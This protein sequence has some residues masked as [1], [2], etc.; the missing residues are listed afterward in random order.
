MNEPGPIFLGVNIDHVAT[1]RQARRTIEPDPVWAAALAEL[2][3]ADGIDGYGKG[4]KQGELSDAVSISFIIQKNLGCFGDG[5]AV[6]TNN[7]DIDRQV[8]ILRNH[9]SKKRSWHSPGFNSRLDDLQAGVLGEHRL[10]AGGGVELHRQGDELK[11]HQAQ[12]ENHPKVDC[13]EHVE[14]EAAD[15]DKPRPPGAG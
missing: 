7:E 9:G 5:G 3:G 2:G 12:K 13:G 1:I 4:F 6:A 8:R 15:D 14:P 10:G 11:R